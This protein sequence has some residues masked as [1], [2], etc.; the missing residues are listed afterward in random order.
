MKKFLNSFIDEDNYGE[1]IGLIAVIFV[2]TAAY[3][4]TSLL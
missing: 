3:L 2:I 4:W 1:L